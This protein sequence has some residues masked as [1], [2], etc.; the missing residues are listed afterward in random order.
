MVIMVTVP[1]AQCQ[2]CPVFV[3]FM[4]Q[5]ATAYVKNDKFRY[6]KMTY[7]I[8]IEYGPATHEIVI[9]LQV[10]SAPAFVIFKSGRKRPDLLEDPLSQ[11]LLSWIKA[12]LD[13]DVTIDPSLVD[14]GQFAAP[15]EGS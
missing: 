6:Q 5:I 1:S 14:L 10:K 4:K 13:V 15:P 9:S 12:E 7:F 8:V 2:V 3:G 11:P